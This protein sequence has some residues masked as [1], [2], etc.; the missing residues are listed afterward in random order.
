[1]SNTNDN[2]K[3]DVV[4]TSSL[5]FSCLTCCNT[6][7]VDCP[8]CKFGGMFKTSTTLFKFCDVCKTSHRVPCYNCSSVTTT[9]NSDLTT[10]LTLSNLDY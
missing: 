5:S 2:K 6:G 3:D 7:F 9:S 10:L 4:E 1:M 8:K